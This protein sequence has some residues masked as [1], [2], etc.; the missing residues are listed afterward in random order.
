MPLAHMSRMPTHRGP[1]L[2]LLALVTAVAPAALHILV[3]ALPSLA[4]IF[5][6]RPAPRAPAARVRRQGAHLKADNAPSGTGQPLHEETEGAMSRLFGPMRQ[7][8]I[9]VRDIEKAMRHLVGR[10]VRRRWPWS[11]SGLPMD[12]YRYKG[13]PLIPRCAHRACQLGRC[14]ARADSSSATMS[15]ASTAISWLPATRVC[16][17]GRAGR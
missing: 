11:S 12:E 8:G 15:Q 16:S 9:V 3:P 17:I 1:P 6:A 10:G 5:D 14:A 13:R 7:V 4:A 2:V